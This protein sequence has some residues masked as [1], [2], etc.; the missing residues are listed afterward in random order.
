MATSV[1]HPTADAVVDAWSLTPRA[2]VLPHFR[3]RSDR[4]GAIWIERKD[5]A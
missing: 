4:A 5:T 1:E 2:T 3:T